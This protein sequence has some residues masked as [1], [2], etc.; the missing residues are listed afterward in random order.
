M[1]AFRVVVPCDLLLPFL[2]LPLL[3][4]SLVKK[5]P[6]Q[7]T[8]WP[9]HLSYDPSDN[10]YYSPFMDGSVPVPSHTAVSQWT[11]QPPSSTGRPMAAFR[12][13]ASGNLLAYEELSH[14]TIDRGQCG[15][16][17]HAFAG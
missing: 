13:V 2:M 9:V 4:I 10:F 7:T 5:T 3:A 1:A 14:W 15:E 12:S 11:I 17:L 8:P 6:H 16:D